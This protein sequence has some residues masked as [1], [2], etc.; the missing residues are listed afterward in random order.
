VAQFE[1]SLGD[2]FGNARVRRRNRRYEINVGVYEHPRTDRGQGYRMPERQIREWIRHAAHVA[3]PRLYKRM[4]VDV[5]RW[6]DGRFSNKV[7][8]PVSIVVDAKQA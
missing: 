7:F 5:G 2:I 8:A 4:T 3:H 1:R 6:Q